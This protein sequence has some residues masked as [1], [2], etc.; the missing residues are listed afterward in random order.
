MVSFKC[1]REKEARAL[2]RVC[3]L[4]VIADAEINIATSL[5]CQNLFDKSEKK[6]KKWNSTKL[7]SYMTVNKNAV[8]VSMSAMRR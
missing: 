3:L 2:F 1:S 7:A 6:H 4:E 5:P 8:A